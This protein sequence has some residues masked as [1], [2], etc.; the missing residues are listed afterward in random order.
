[1]KTDE[2]LLQATGVSKRFKLYPSPT[3]RLK[4]WISLGRTKRHEEFWAL[5][6]INLKVSRGECLGVVGSN[7][8][9]KSTLLKILSGALA[10][11][12]GK[13]E[14]HGKAY[15]LI[16]LATGFNRVLT[17]RDN[18]LFVA[19]MLGFDESV[20]DER[21]QEIIDFAEL[22]DFIDQPVRMYSSG[23]VAR[24]GFSLFAFLDPD[25]LMIDEVLSVGDAGFKRKCIAH[26]ERTVASGDR[27]AV[28]VSHS[29]QTVSQLCDRCIWLHRGTQCAVGPTD[30]VLAV[31]QQ[32]MAR[33][34]AECPDAS[35]KV[36][37]GRRP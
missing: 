18:I 27:A 1:M 8:S 11:T 10:P 16:E 37:E 33:N 36:M 23:M 26:L 29:L 20:V 24:L 19:Q 3:D 12:S 31:F 13:V 15:A 21:R 32:M 7:G 34:A 30:E 14:A 2:T 25:I 9:G 6:D 35:S 17:G 4:E 22:G 5:K 28:F